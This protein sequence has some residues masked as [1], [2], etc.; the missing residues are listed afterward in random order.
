MTGSVLDILIYVFDRY[1]LD[2]VPEVPEREHL[3]RD[4]ERVGFTQANVER[5]LDWLAELA[6]ERDRP[7]LHLTEEVYG[8]AVRIFSDGE[9]AR[10][11][12]ECR[13]FLVTLERL[14]ILSPQQREIVIDRMLALDS[15]ELDTEQLKWVVLMVLSSQPGQEQAFERL[16]GLVADAQPHAPH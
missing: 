5:A 3:A 14:G 12:T 15:D 6:S 1:M 16:E 9:L 11:S 2:E 13:G 8:R 10:L 7:P 4:L